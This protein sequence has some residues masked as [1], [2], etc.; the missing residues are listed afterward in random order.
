[1]MKK[2]IKIIVLLVLIAVLSACNNQ[3]ENETTSDAKDSSDQTTTQPDNEESNQLIEIGETH[4]FETTLGSYKMNLKNVVEKKVVDSEESM[5]GEF[6]IPEFSIENTGDKAVK[7]ESIFSTFDIK[8]PLIMISQTRV[9]G[10]QKDWWTKEIQPGETLNGKVYYDMKAGKTYEI[11]SRYVT[12]DMEGTKT[13][14]WKF[15]NEEVEK[16]AE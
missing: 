8:T 15:S 3:S 7:V 16:D 1:M 4:N 6:I 11:K 9:I 12:A 2:T 14:G 13:L 5:N 10:D